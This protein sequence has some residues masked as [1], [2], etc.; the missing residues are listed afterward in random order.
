MR[1]DRSEQSGT[2]PIRYTSP[3]ESSTSIQSQLCSLLASPHILCLAADS[4]S[5]PVLVWQESKCEVI[6][7]DLWRKKRHQFAEPLRLEVTVQAGTSQTHR[8]V[9]NYRRKIHPCWLDQLFLHNCPSAAISHLHLHPLCSDTFIHRYR[10][11]LKPE[12]TNP[13]ASTHLLIKKTTKLWS[14]IRARPLIMLRIQWKWLFQKWQSSFC[15]SKGEVVRR[16]ALI[17]HLVLPGL[18][19]LT[20]PAWL[21]CI[22]R[23]SEGETSGGS[24]STGSHLVLHVNKDLLPAEKTISRCNI[25]KQSAHKSHL[26]GAGRT[27]RH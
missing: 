9:G 26:P 7:G 22:N 18:A 2:P 8:Q 11:G 14:K 1:R 27:R 19:S 20:T 24:E 10:S 25:H 15:A 5:S 21:R 13:E 16:R 17:F 6:W 3:P 23:Q 4:E 12:G